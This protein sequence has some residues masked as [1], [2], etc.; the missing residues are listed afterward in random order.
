MLRPRRGSASRIYTPLTNAIHVRETF[1][2]EILLAHGANLDPMAL[3]EAIHCPVD[4]KLGHM[5]FLIDRGVD[6]NYWTE[7]WGTPL[8]HAVLARSTSKVRL[9]L[10]NGADRTIRSVRGRTAVEQAQE[11]HQ[12]E[13]VALLQRTENA[14]SK[15]SRFHICACTCE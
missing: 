1:A 5:R 15:G 3:H 8:Y 9:L 11:D 12:E 7:S 14:S 13:L 4:S 10:E 2:L 6:I